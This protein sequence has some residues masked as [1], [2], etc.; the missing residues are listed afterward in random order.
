MKNTD[1]SREGSRSARGAGVSEL[2]E[3]EVAGV[4]H[5]SP[6]RHQRDA[7]APGQPD[8]EQVAVD[9]EVGPQEDAGPPRPHAS[10]PMAVAASEILGSPTRGQVQAGT[11]RVESGAEHGVDVVDACGVVDEDEP[12]AIR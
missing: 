8:A 12:A 1:R 3:G 9:A 5:E 6:P 4:H 2:G 10:G 7:Q 11:A